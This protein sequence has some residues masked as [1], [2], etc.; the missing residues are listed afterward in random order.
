MKIKGLRIKG[1]PC[2]INLSLYFQPS[3]IKPI[4]A[5]AVKPYNAKKSVTVKQL[6]TVYVNDIRPKRLH[7]D[8][9]KKRLKSAG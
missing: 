2:G 6:V 9:N 4:I 7:R 3:F 5:V 1:T 8:I